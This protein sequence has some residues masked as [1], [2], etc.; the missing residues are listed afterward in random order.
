MFLYSVGEEEENERRSSRYV[1]KLA[2]RILPPRRSYVC[3]TVVYRG[4]GLRKKRRGELLLENRVMN[5]DNLENIDT[6]D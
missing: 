1:Q 4:S 5:F 3:D 6:N 2:A